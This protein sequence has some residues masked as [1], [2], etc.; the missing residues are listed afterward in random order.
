[1]SLVA[2]PFL[3]NFWERE[4]ETSFSNVS[5]L[6]VYDPKT[7]FPFL[8]NKEKTALTKKTKNQSSQTTFFCEHTHDPT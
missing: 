7:I 1:M 2:F 3:S 4:R 6:T 8:S 5:I